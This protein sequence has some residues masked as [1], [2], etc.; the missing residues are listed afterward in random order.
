MAQEVI[1]ALASGVGPVVGGAFSQ[2]IGWPWIWWINLPLSGL[3]FILLLLF[4]NVHNPKTSMIDG[5]KALDWAGTLSILAVTLMVLLGLEFGGQTFPWSSS[6]VIC[7]IVFGSLMSLV[8]IWCEKRVARFPLM[9]MSIF[10]NRSN[11]GCMAL[12]F[13]HAFVSTYKDDAYG[14]G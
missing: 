13:V 6:R 5:L 4:L 2:G 8:F 12:N 11:V 10:G 7:L 9:P 3:A 14:L 1:W